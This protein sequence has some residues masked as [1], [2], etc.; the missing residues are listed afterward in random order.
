MQEINVVIIDRSEVFAKAL[1]SMLLSNPKMKNIQLFTSLTDG[2]NSIITDKP[3]VVLLDVNIK[4]EKD[5][6]PV[7]IILQSIMVPI[8][9]I[10]ENTVFQTAKTVQALSQGA[11]DF[12]KL[13]QKIKQELMSKEKEIFHKVIQASHGKKSRSIKLQNKPSKVITNKVPPKGSYPDKA[14]IAIGSST[15]GPRALHM[16]IQHLPSNFATPILIVQ[17]MPA[18]FTKSLAERL[19]KIGNIHVKE[20]EHGE[21]IR[22]GTVYVAPGN[23]HMKVIETNSKLSIEITQ[24]EER[25]GHRPSVNILFDSVAKIKNIHKIAVVLTGM[26]KD[27]AE[28]VKTIKESQREAIII[29]ESK[30]T[31]IINGMPKSVIETNFVTDV[32]RID[33]IA[34][35]LI[36]Y[37]KK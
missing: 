37:T 22:R 31:A 8:L 20:A 33:N 23:Y 6:L 27:G 28:G 35:A 15:G 14:L 5:E 21:I 36:D 11:I 13:D 2:L 18:G 30:E 25:L 10:A 24:E 32:L 3:H 19:N 16:V 12:I 26:G 17:H 4:G 29:A 1:K 34:Q 9:M 7:K